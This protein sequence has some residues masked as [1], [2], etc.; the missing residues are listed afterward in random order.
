MKPLLLRSAYLP[1]IDYIQAIASSETTF[2]ELGET[3][4]KQS[5]RNRCE[6][7]TAQGKMPLSIPVKRPQGNRTLTQ[8]IEIDYSTAWQRVHLGAIRAAYA[9]SAY[10]EHYYPELEGIVLSKEK[11]LHALN[12]RLLAFLLTRLGLS[13]RIEYRAEYISPSD[14]EGFL[15]LRESIHP[16]RE[17]STKGEYYQTFCDRQPFIRNASALD[18]LMNEG[19][20]GQL[21]LRENTDS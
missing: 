12:A 3:Y 5:Y 15:D 17:R 11:L 7:V 1:P 9:K 18:L 2:I 4:A 13:P 21:L 20:E 14:A 19:P 16:K 10:Y 6:L 8:D